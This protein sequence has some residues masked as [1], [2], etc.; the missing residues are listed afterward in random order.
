MPSLFQLERTRARIWTF[1]KDYSQTGDLESVRRTAETRATGV[2]LIRARLGVSAD[3]VDGFDGVPP[4]VPA[5]TAPIGT[6]A[7]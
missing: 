4:G 6:K 2:G 1:Y 5:A 7:W 3:C